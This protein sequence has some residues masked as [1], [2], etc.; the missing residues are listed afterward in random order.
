MAQDQ[1]RVCKNC[2]KACGTE[3][4]GPRFNMCITCPRSEDTNTLRRTP[5]QR[6]AGEGGLCVIASSCFDE[7][8]AGLASVESSQR[9]CLPCSTCTL[10]V[11]YE[12][13]ACSY[14]EN[15]VC[16]DVTEPCAG[17]ESKTRRQQ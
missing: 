1:D 14:S 8:Y 17:D 11:T 6:A 9:E 12:V 16:K 4:V 13:T 5:K 2:N 3:C 15:R 10:N 7:T